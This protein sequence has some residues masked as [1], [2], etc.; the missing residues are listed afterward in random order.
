[1]VLLGVG[2]TAMCMDCCAGKTLHLHYI[3][4]AGKVGNASMSTNT[5]TV[6][7][8]ASDTTSSMDS[9]SSNTRSLY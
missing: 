5:N 1:M 8:R 4:V 9:K 7:V 2:A 6:V 3:T